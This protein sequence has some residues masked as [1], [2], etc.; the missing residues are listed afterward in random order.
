ME[1][2]NGVEAAV[3]AA[4]VCKVA[5]II[6]NNDGI[7]DAVSWVADYN[8]AL[9]DFRGDSAVS[10][11]IGSVMYDKRVL[12]TSMSNDIRKAAFMR[13]PLVL[14][15]HNI[16]NYSIVFLPQ[17]SQEVFDDLVAAYAIAEDRKVS[18]PV[19]VKS[20][21]LLNSTYESVDIPTPKMIDNMIGELR[22]EKPDKHVKMRLDNDLNGK[23][24]LQKTID[25]SRKVLTDFSEKWKKKFKRTIPILDTFMTEDAYTIIVVYGPN[26]GNAML[27]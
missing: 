8:P 17:S 24:Q 27:A 26:S 7:F 14:F 12:L 16:K 19:V 18:I 6:G 20:D 21:P 3:Q 25:Y 9:L 13:V 1:I 23:V 22:M 2:L 10:A 15:Y 11:G 5:S 4:R